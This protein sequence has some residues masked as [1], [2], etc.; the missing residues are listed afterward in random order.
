MRLKSFALALAAITSLAAPAFGAVL[1][2]IDITGANDPVD[3]GSSRTWNFSVTQ[4]FEVS[5]SV[6]SVKRGS[7]T[8]QP[9]VFSLYDALGGTGN[10]LRSYTLAAASEDTSY[11]PPTVFD[12]ANITLTPGNYS[13]TLTSSTGTNGAFQYFLKNGAIKLYNDNGAPIPTMDTTTALSSSFYNTDG[14]TTG[15]STTTSSPV[16]PEPSSLSILA[17]T[18]L[19]ALRRRRA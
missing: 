10:L 17:L 13:A 2:S 19:L 6:F 11:D 7:Q 16:I 5:R 14:N 3:S 15:T 4:S 9:I 12:F 1:I 18:G 8:N